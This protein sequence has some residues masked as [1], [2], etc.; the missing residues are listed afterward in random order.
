MPGFNTPKIYDFLVREPDSGTNIGTEV[1]TTL[2]DTICL[3]SAQVPRDVSVIV[4]GRLVRTLQIPVNGVGYPTYCLACDLV[5]NVNSVALR[6]A[7][8]AAQVP[9]THGGRPDQSLP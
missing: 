6:S 4:N 3:N 9:F 1:K 7:L 8:Q 5:P 2:Y